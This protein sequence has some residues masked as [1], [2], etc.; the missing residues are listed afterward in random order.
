MRWNEQFSLLRTDFQRTN[1][2]PQLVL[3][4]SVTKNGKFR[5][6]PLDDESL[7]IVEHFLQKPLSKHGYL[8]YNPDT[9]DRVNSNRSSWLTCLRKSN[10]TDFRWHDLR[11]TYA[12]DEIRNGMPIYQLSKL[13]GHSNV[14][15]T[16]KYAHLY[17][18]DLHEAKRKASIMKPTMVVNNIP[19]D[20]IT[21]DNKVDTTVFVKP[22][23]DMEE[24]DLF[25]DLASENKTPQNLTHTSVSRN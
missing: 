24:K 25:S 13:L 9:E 2:G 16:E 17:V 14:Q 3:R 11:H 20:T 4:D 10:I 18:E 19:T 22:N 1:F 8:F 15:V 7:E 23:L 12:T 6:V 5:V 21:S